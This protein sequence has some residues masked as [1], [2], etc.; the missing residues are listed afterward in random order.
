MNA[1][2]KEWID[3]AE[4]DFATAG[5]EL[6]AAESPNFDAVCF[7]SQ[8]CVEK[9]MKAALIHL[10]VL[11]PK[12]HDLVTLDRLLGP[13]WPGW[14]WRPDELRF[15]SNA[16]IASRYPRE[17][18]DKDEAAES[19]KVAGKIREKLRTLMGIRL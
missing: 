7:H 1:T 3:K 18:A 6:H 2:V 9:L 4:G 11:P 17:S 13:A 19:Y 14:S 12:T 15:L 10:G 8:P 5:R 16:A